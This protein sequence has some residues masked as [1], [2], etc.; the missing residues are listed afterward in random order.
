MKLLDSTLL[1][2]VLL[3]Q[4]YTVVLQ[5]PECNPVIITPS[6]STCNVGD[7][8]YLM[9]GVSRA[10]TVDYATLAALVTEIVDVQCHGD[11]N[12]AHY[13]DCKLLLPHQL[14]VCAD[15]RVGY[16]IQ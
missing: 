15:T 4:I 6:S 16:E 10:T 14:V 8:G 1:V 11:A 12:L 2:F 7:I 3:V 5:H 9:Y 13:I